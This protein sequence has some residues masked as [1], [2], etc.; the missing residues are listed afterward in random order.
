[1][2]FH[3]IALEESAHSNTAGDCVE[4]GPVRL[5]PVGLGP[6]PRSISYPVGPLL[7]PT[8][9]ISHRVSCLSIM[10][11]AD[12]EIDLNLS[13]VLCVWFKCALLHYLLNGPA[14]SLQNG[15]NLIEIKFATR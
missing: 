9:L 1:M 7:P 11:L 5:L 10:D 13:S 14:S 2:S 12:R 4:E 6:G 8:P 15:E 3:G